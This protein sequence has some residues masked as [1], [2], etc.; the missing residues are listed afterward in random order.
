MDVIPRLDITAATR[1]VR[2]SDSFRA[3]RSDTARRAASTSP[4]P[5]ASP[6]DKHALF[7]S[8]VRGQ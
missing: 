3:A 2:R 6:S 4:S 5:A 7:Y 8:W 1:Y